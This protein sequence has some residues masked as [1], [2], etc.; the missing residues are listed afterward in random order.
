M[1]EGM[2]AIIGH[3]LFLVGISLITFYFT[4][5]RIMFSIQ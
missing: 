3:F 4:P 1:V 2:H 5:E